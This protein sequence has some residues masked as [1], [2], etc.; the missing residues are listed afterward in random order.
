MRTRVIITGGREYLGTPEAAAWLSAQLR[1]LDP[2]EIYHG[3]A[4]GAD[5]WAA[6]LIQRTMAD[7]YPRVRARAVPGWQWRRYRGAAGN[8]RNERMADEAGRDGARFV[9]LALPGGPGT[10]HMC[11]TA[12]ARGMEVRAYGV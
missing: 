10:A 4:R 11:A 1:E 8:M 2:E 6:L 3:A 12:R 9:V 7:L 5:T